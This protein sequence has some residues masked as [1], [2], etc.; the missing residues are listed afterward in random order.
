MNPEVLEAFEFAAQADAPNTQRAYLADWKH[1]LAW[2]KNRNRCP[3]PVAPTILRSIFGI[4]RR[5]LGSK[6]RRCSAGCRPSPRLML[7]TA[8]SRRPA[9]GL[10]E[11]PCGGFD[12]ISVPRPAGRTRCWSKT[13]RRCSLT[14]PRRLP[15]A[16][17]RLS[18]S[19]AFAER[20]AGAI[21]STSISKTS[22]KPMKASCSWSEKE[23]PTRSVKAG[24]SGFRTARIL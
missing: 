1:F 12:A 21:S 7:A 2:C 8:I 20:F 24:R 3:L 9:N 17:T 5:S 6:F 14:A 10:C 23:R 16:V 22:P 19:S 15:G 4:V 13:S 11:T 18:C